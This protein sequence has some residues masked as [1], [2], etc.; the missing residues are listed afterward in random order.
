[1]FSYLKYYTGIFKVLYL[2][3]TVNLAFIMLTIRAATVVHS[4]RL[5]RSSL[6][7][8]DKKL[9]HIV[10]IVPTMWHWHFTCY[11]RREILKI[12]N[13]DAAVWFRMW[14]LSKPNMVRIFVYTSNFI[15]SIY[16]S[17]LNIRFEYSGKI[18]ALGK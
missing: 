16:F 15:L 6:Y 12:I 13:R 4:S 5:K 7:N 2:R 3:L 11:P 9:I 10:Y 1:M 17:F 14:A 18:Y 8:S